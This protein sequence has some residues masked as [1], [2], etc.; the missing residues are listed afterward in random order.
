M[1]DEGL[2][3]QTLTF[4]M[5]SQSW[6][7]K[8]RDRTHQTSETACLYAAME[9]DQEMIEVF[10]EEPQAMEISDGTLTE[11]RGQ[12]TII[13]ILKK[14]FYKP[15]LATMPDEIAKNISAIINGQ[16]EVLFPSI[17]DKVMDA[18]FSAINANLTGRFGSATRPKQPDVMG[19]LIGM[20]GQ[21][22]MERVISS[23]QWQCN[24]QRQVME[25]VIPAMLEE[26]RGILVQQMMQ[27][28]KPTVDQIIN[29]IFPAME[30]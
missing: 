8:K 24:M 30:P 16:V 14:Q 10:G 17:I 15:V 22:M 12:I 2:L 11:Q 7:H 20:M 28:V 4:L 25:E 18:I 27:M 26:I 23:L 29:D 13:N 1:S 6:A 9:H 21:T 3:K 5:T 19:H